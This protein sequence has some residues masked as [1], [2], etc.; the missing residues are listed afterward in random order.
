[1]LDKQF[2]GDPQFHSFLNKH[3]I[4]FHAVRGETEG[5]NV[6]KKYGIRATPTVLIAD[7]DGS[8]IDRQV[9]YGPP[10]KK[11]QGLIELSLTGE[12]TFAKLK[13]RYEQNP[14]DLMTTFKLAQKY[15]RMYDPVKTTELISKVL[16]KAKEAKMLD[17]KNPSTDKNVNMYEWARYIKAGQNRGDIS[18]FI[19]FKN[20]FPE[21][22]FTETVLSRIGSFYSYQGAGDEALDFFNENLEKF[23]DNK[24]LKN[25]F[26]NY[27]IQTKSNLE[28]GIKVAEEMI[29]GELIPNPYN[30]NTYARIL[31]ANEDYDKLDEIY[32]PDNISSRNSTYAYGLFNY[33]TFWNKQ[34]E[35]LESAEKMIKMA[36][37]MVPD[38]A[39]YRS[40]AADICIKNKNYAD[41]DKLFGPEFIATRK[42]KR[43]DVNSYI[44]FWAGQGKHL[45]NALELANSPQ[46]L[47]IVYVAMGEDEKAISCYGPKFLKENESNANTLN[48]YAWFWAQKG[49]NLKSAAKAVEKSI[50]KNPT[51]FVWDT[52]S[53]VYQK[54]GKYDKA[55]KAE[56][57]ALELSPNNAG[58]KER[59]AEIKKEM[60]KSERKVSQNR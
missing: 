11:F 27:C 26:V 51:H 14:N 59:L 19:Q 53:M 25:Y 18:G 35:N 40:L 52:A 43:A 49:K 5:D 39:Y 29:E 31:E 9:G 33:A 46:L 38:R 56:E 28:R 7:V 57:K 2:F 13:K 60:K 48:S 47:A 6:Y 16:D 44:R 17:I 4:A 45:E 32:S 41:A 36:I 58:Y 12:D 55:I 50:E 24:G 54:M 15:E 21:S 34:E 10:A 37:N 22:E 23:P 1:M 8:E 42:D 3:F 20:D 30:F